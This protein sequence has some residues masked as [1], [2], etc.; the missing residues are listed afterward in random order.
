MLKGASVDVA[1]CAAH[2]RAVLVATVVERGCAVTAMFINFSFPFIELH[3][4]R[5]LNA[6]NCI[7]FA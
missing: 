6:E 3:M 4:G 5:R 2:D 7:S 1:L